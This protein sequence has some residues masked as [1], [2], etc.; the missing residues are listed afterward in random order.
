MY[1]NTTEYDDNYENLDE[2]KRSKIEHAKLYEIYIINQ[3]G[4]IVQPD[5]SKG[6]ITVDVPVP[7]D[8]DLADLEIYRI[9]EDADDDFDE[10][11]VDINNRNYCEFETDHFSPYTMIDENTLND[12]IQTILPYLLLLLILL[13][14][15][16]LIIILIKRKKD[17]EEEE[18]AKQQQ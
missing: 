7:N 13:F 11:V 15:I 4:Q 5:I 12:I 1:P 18:E 2:E 8:Y 9:K 14:L 10:R 6:L 17:E 16:L 3:D